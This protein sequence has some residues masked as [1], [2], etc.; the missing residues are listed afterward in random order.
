MSDIRGSVQIMYFILFD[1][2]WIT[3][4]TAGRS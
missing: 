3:A 2:A 4:G 1:G